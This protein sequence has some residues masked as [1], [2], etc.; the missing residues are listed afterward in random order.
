MFQHCAAPL[1]AGV[2]CQ[3]GKD[4]KSYSGGFFM[5]DVQE[6]LGDN[7]HIAVKRVFCHGYKIYFRR[8]PNEFNQGPLYIEVRFNNVTIGKADFQDDT[9]SCHCD[10]IEVQEEHRRKGIATALYVLVELLYK[11]SICNFW[12]NDSSNI[13]TASARALWSQENRP[14]GHKKNTC[15]HCG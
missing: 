9:Y 12:G 3:A 14:F 7:P 10:N 4:R 6:V 11:E 8:E 1:N 15:P 2:R 13:Q 5:Q